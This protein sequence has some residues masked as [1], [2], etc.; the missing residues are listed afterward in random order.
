M[1]NSD[2]IT[3]LQRS[4]AVAEGK[5]KDLEAEESAIK[6]SI[7]KHSAVIRDADEVRS[8]PYSYPAHMNAT[9][10]RAAA[11]RERSAASA[12][13]N[14][15]QAECNTAKISLSELRRELGRAQ[16]EAK[17]DS[18]LARQKQEVTTAIKSAGSRMD[19]LQNDIN[20][21]RAKR[22]VAKEALKAL[23]AAERELSEAEQ[24]LAEK[25]ADA[26]IDGRE[27]DLSDFEAGIAKARQA[28]EDAKVDA[29]GASAALPRLDERI[30]AANEALDE[31]TANSE[32]LIK[33]YFDIQL[34]MAE[35]EYSK[36]AHGLMNGLQT[37]V[38]IGQITGNRLGDGLLDKMRSSLFVPV[39]GKHVTAL[40]A[41]PWFG[42]SVIPDVSHV[43]ARLTADLHAIK[44][45]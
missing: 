28:L 34:R 14:S 44:E 13:L 5:I 10:A 43:T 29:V 18:E 7:D 25:Q 40:D 39:E 12:K 45:L 21:L 33:A 2:K 22:R 16:Y 19:G 35:R 26:Y 38:A 4:I 3:A 31:E 8:S 11:L 1:N 9:T 42:C 15:L 20:H 30:A 41:A 6:R 23:S 24:A 36:H 37:L 17:S 32:S 27:A